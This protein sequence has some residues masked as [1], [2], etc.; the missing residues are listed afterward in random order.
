VGKF[1]EAKWTWSS[2]DDA[3]L[4]GPSSRNKPEGGAAAAGS[5]ARIVL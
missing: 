2:M 1:G 5:A 3:R 4:G